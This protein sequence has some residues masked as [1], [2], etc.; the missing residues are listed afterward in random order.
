MLRRGPNADSIC[1]IAAH[2]R[3]PMGRFASKTPRNLRLKGRARKPCSSVQCQERRRPSPKRLH[4]TPQETDLY[5]P[6]TQWASYLIN[7]LK[8]KELQKRDVNYIVRGEEVFTRCYII[9]INAYSGPD[10]PVKPP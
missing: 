1:H 2:Y 10:P 7:A 5:D 4:C 8:A 9:H 6:R 3:S